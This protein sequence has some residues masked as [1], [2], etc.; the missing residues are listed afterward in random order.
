MPEAKSLLQP[1][2]PAPWFTAP[3]PAGMPQKF[4]TLGGRYVVLS[5]FG[6]TARESSRLLL[7]EIT[8]RQDLFNGQDFIFCGLSI[9]PADANL[10]MEAGPG[11]RFF[12]DA[13]RAISRQYGAAPLAAASPDLYRRMTLVLDERLRTLAVLLLDDQNVAQ[14]LAQLWSILAKLP[15][16]GDETPAQAPVL[17]IPRVF[18]PQLCRELIAYYDQHGGQASGFMREVDGQTVEVH[19]PEHKRRRDQE[20]LDE[21]LRQRAMFAVHARV[22]PEIQKA[23]QFTC[24]RIE[25]HMVACYD[26]SEGGHFRAHRDNTTKGTAHR[27]FAVSLNLNTGEYDGG[28]LRFPEYGRHLYEAPAGGAVVFSCSLLHEATRVTRGKRYAYLPFL[29]DEAAAR[30]REANQKFVGGVEGARDGGRE[31]RG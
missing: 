28:Q 17:V 21:S 16:L 8:A 30:V 25:R 11:I 6:S 23:F 18:P 9:D 26:S 4:E 14:H 7:S 22:M 10:L 12:L 2:D 3:N 5:L 1:G 13:D 31:A 29:Y 20:I 15:P 19:N 24:S 27:R